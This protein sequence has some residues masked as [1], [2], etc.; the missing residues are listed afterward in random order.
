MKNLVHF[1]AFLLLTTGSLAQSPDKFHYQAVLRDTDNN[2]AINK[3][4]K[5][6]LS[7]ISQEEA[8]EPVY[9][10]EHS[11]QTNSSGLVSLEIGSGSNSTG[12]L[13]SIDWP[14]EIL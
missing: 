14:N 13:S 11:S 10:E 3:N 6:T 2:L 12:S 1:F 8:S 5:L 4:V 7:I 9:S